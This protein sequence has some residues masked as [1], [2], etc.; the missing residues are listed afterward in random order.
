ME[1]V[2]LTTNAAKNLSIL[3]SSTKATLLVEPGNNYTV[4]IVTNSVEQK[5]SLPQTKLISSGKDKKKY[6]FDSKEVI[7]LSGKPLNYYFQ[8]EPSC[9]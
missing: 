2:S 6:K 1:L 9:L 3:F 4:T 5:S 8:S 7:V